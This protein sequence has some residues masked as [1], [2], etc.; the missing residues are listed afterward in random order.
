V[1][2]V[3]C[4]QCSTEFTTKHSHK[5]YCSRQCQIDNN[6]RVLWDKTKLNPRD[7]CRKL[8]DQ[9]KGRS[10]LKQLPF[11]LT[12]DFL[13]RLWTEQAG[14]C[15]ISDIP[16]NLDYPEVPRTP[17]WDSPSLD[18]IDPSRGYVEGN[19]RLVLYQVNCGIGPYGLEQF[20]SLCRAVK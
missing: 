10:K 6:A 13:Y 15:C 14:R 20:Q 18:R 3:I 7:R 12:V 5:R 9:A 2:L 19:I 1:R 17:R 11:N 4:P 16:F 8:L